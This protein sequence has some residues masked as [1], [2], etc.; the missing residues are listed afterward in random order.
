MQNPSNAAEFIGNR[1][2]LRSLRIGSAAVRP[3]LGQASGQCDVT[4]RP[5]ALAILGNGKSSKPRRY[6]HYT[7]VPVF[8]FLTVRDLISTWTGGGCGNGEG[9][10][11]SWCGGQSN[12][13]R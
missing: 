2:G 5:T 3:G 12:G 1:L 9:R 10:N 7:D 4:P 6:L 8:K 13:V 11:R